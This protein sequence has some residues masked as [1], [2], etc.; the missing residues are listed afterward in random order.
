MRLLPNMGRLLVKLG[1]ISE[2]TES[3]LYIPESARDTGSAKV[4]TVVAL[5][6]ERIV[7]GEKTATRP[8]IGA[9][10]LIDPLGSL[11][12]KFGSEELYLLRCEDVLGIIDE[13]V[14]SKPQ[15]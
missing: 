11:K 7:N 4:G 9:K 10:V 1:E 5:G 8:W 13:K 2:K 6:E 12:V 15:E 3:G 14:L